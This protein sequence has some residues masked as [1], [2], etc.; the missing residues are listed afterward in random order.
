[1]FI[2]FFQRFQTVEE[3]HLSQIMLFVQ[4]YIDVLQSD[5]KAM[6]QILQELVNKYSQLTID[7]LLDKFVLTKLTGLE[8]PSK[9]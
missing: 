9:Y 5:R 7:R 1:M 3:S 4:T 8:K 2:T 6:G